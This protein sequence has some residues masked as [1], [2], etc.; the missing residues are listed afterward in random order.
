[1]TE[2]QII[3][4]TITELLGLNFYIPDYQ[5]GYRWTKNNVT[6]LLNDIWE[7]RQEKSNQHT[8]YCLQPVVVRKCTWGNQYGQEVEGYELIDGQQ[9]LTTLHRVITYLMLEHLKIDSLNAD[10]KEELYELHYQTRPESA[11]FLQGSEYNNSKPDL[12]Y[13]SEA[14]ENIKNWFEDPARGFGRTEKNRFLDVLLPERIELKDGISSTIP[15]WSVQVIWYEI[16][17]ETQKSEDLFARLNRGKIPLTSSELIKAKFVNA[18]SFK[19]LPDDVKLKRRTQLVQIWDEIE[20]HLNNKRFWAFIS[21]DKFAKYSNKIEYLF[22]IVTNKKKQELD[23]LYSFIHFFD[24]NEN[25]ETLWDKWIKV[26]EM[27]RALAFWY[28]DKNYYHKIGYL[29]ATGTSIVDLVKKKNTYSKTEFKNYIDQLIADTI[30]DDWEELHYDNRSDQDKIIRVLLLTNVELTRRSDNSNE[31]FPFEMYKEIAKS[32]EHIHAQNIEDINENR[33]AD[34]FNWLDAHAGIL[35][36]V[37]T[38]KSAAEKLLNEIET[39]NREKYQFDDFKSL[40]NRLLNL[41][42][43]EEGE[44]ANEYLHKIENMALLGLTEN[45]ALSNSVF[46]V[47]RKKVIEMDKNGTFIPLATKRGF[48]KYYAEDGNPAPLLWTRQERALYMAEI[49]NCIESYKP[50]RKESNEE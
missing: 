11:T 30:P 34:W 39:I 36:N 32:L 13:M 5:R 35:L 18:D 50:L 20:N 45:I 42:P 14:Y 37:A 31:F 48:L 21:N 17:D 40:S 29:I 15:E 26:E 38:N 47:K 1:M 27:Y 22:D 9:R 25:A 6:Q 46:E 19:G 41:L 7:Y 3:T 12:Y 16:N 24:H 33:R 43:K 23:N 28:T 10:Y 49:T 44:N 8:F 2:N 4:K